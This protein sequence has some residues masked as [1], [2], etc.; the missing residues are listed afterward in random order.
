MA[1]SLYH[2]PPEQVLVECRA[3]VFSYD[4]NR[5]VEVGESTVY[6]RVQLICSRPPGSTVQ[7][8]VVARLES[9][10]MVRNLT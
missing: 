7:Y 3:I 8:R 10:G 9:T 4:I 2:L 6:S 5:W 1:Q